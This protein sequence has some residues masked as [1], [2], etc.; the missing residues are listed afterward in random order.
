MVCCFI[1]RLNSQISVTRGY[2]FKMLE[3]KAG[4]RA[5]PWLLLGEW[6]RMRN[7]DPLSTVIQPVYYVHRSY[8]EFKIADLTIKLSR[9][10]APAVGIVVGCLHTSTSMATPSRRRRLVI[11]ES[12]SSESSF[13]TNDD[14]T[15]LSSEDEENEHSTENVN[16]QF[17]DGLTASMSQVKLSD[18][19]PTKNQ[20]SGSRAC[21]RGGINSLAFDSESEESDS[22][23][24]SYVPT[25]K[26]KATSRPIVV[27]D[28]DATDSDDD[29]SIDV[30][31][32]DS[33]NSEEE[34][35]FQS[36][37]QD[38]SSSSEDE[39]E[40]NPDAKWS[41]N[42]AR[43]EFSV[44]STADI[45]MPKLTVPTKVFKKLFDYQKDGVVWMAGLH[46]GRIGG[47]LGD[48]MGLGKTF[49][50]LTLLGGLMRAKTIRNALVVAPLSVLRSWEREANAVA[51]A[52]VPHIR[53]QVV[54]SDISKAT[55]SRRLQDALEW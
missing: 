6:R 14:G 47:L 53:I 7:E 29:E 8:V 49:Q 4:A 20:P 2:F 27:A 11:E 48:D 31:Y 38:F 32:S 36:P 13:S 33:R 39:N 51:K 42:R 1:F 17:T 43:E 37:K 26:P 3:S 45:N 46:H 52:C 22:S 35:S 24:E 16:S 23:I 9:F 34:E 18:D 54:S 5:N 44:A 40:D 25:F 41:Y 10:V 28:S 21:A 30:E 50:T 15:T 12:P 19:A 55:R